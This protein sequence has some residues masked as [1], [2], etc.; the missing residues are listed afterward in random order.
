M[1]N[2][3]KYLKECI[4]SVLNQTMM[5]YEIILVN[6]GSTDGSKEISEQYSD[7][8]SNIRLI[9]QENKGLSAAR[10]RGLDAANGEYICFL[11][12][13]DMFES[14]MLQICID[15]MEEHSLDVLFFDYKIKYEYNTNE[16]SVE[17]NN[18]VIPQNVL[19]TGKQ[20]FIKAV[21]N[22]KL[23]VSAC[24]KCYKTNF[25][26][27]NG[28]RFQNGLLYEDEDFTPRQLM[29]AKRVMNIERKLYVYRKRLNS[30]TTTRIG[31]KNLDSIKKI[32]FNMIS[33]AQQECENNIELKRAF[34]RIIA[35][36]NRQ[37]SMFYKEVSLIEKNEIN[38]WLNRYLD[39]YRDVFG[40]ELDTYEYCSLGEVLERLFENSNHINKE[41]FIGNIDKKNRYICNLAICE[42]NLMRKRLLSKVP[43]N[44]YRINVGIYGVGGHTREL[45]EFYEK[46]IGSIKCN[47]FFIDSF[48]G[49]NSETIYGKPIIKVDKINNYNLDCI[50]LS[51]YSY[52]EELYYSVKK[53][54]K[55]KIKIIKFYEK[56]DILLFT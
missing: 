4:D 24:S 27:K 45:L 48:K 39:N 33:L 32:I 5:N 26:M 51:S 43:F 37:L 40:N 31:S 14:N 15:K 55:K 30:I 53:N 47:L 25:L 36:D 13:D 21:L 1:Y 41:S 22:D 44:D 35:Y 7:K 49:E 46:N 19:M 23:K 29:E 2:V 3:K 18:D 28:L 50:V 38:K 6:D 17:K 52:E 12:S 20:Y 8:F 54:L 16:N 42:F 11:D 9:N 56:N 10:N 34:K